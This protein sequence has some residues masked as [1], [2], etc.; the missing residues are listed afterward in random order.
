MQHNQQTKKAKEEQNKK[1]EESITLILNYEQTIYEYKCYLKDLLEKYFL[2]FEKSTN[3]DH[4]YIYILYRGVTFYGKKFKKPISEII[5][6]Q[7]KKDKIMT[8][9]IYIDTELNKNDLDEIK[10][11]LA[12]ES[13]KIYKL[14]G[15]R[16]ELIIDIIRDSP[17]FKLDL[18]CC[19][20][21]YK[22]KEIDINQKFDDI[23]N[24]EDKKI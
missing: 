17:N 3:I 7:D 13:V 23:A 9:L 21:T 6:D 1:E 16:R 18:K 5:N 22:E 2:I 4:S 14:K 24:D 10:I 20:F 11:V 8:L 15:E 12:L 19:I